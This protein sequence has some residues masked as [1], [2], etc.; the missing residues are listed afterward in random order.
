VARLARNSRVCIQQQNPCSYKK[1]TIQNKLR[2][3]PKD[4]IRG[5]K[6]EEVQSSREICGENEENSGRS[7]GSTR[8]SIGRN[9]EVCRPKMGEGG[10]IQSRGLSTA[11][12]KRLEIA[13]EGKKIGKVDKT[14]CGPL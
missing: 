11:E 2:P 7:K 8:K 3:K 4:G 9:E 12:Y 6:E 10:G 1:L 13:N 14:F 5:K